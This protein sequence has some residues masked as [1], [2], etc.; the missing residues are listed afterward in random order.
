[1]FF[2][3]VVC[4]LHL[5]SHWRNVTW[6]QRTN[7]GTSRRWCQALNLWRNVSTYQKKFAQKSLFHVWSPKLKQECF[8]QKWLMLSEVI[9]KTWQDKVNLQIKRIN[10]LSKFFVC[11]IWECVKVSVNV[12]KIVVWMCFRCVY[13]T[14]VNLKNIKEN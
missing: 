4:R 1:M 13:L 2:P 3:T 6:P 10:F 12:F 14:L 8:A 5:L 7:A 11:M 9:Q